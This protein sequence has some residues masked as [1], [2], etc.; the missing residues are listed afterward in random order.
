V[1]LAE[2]ASTP[3]A[4]GSDL[5]PFAGDPDFMLSLARGMLVLRCFAE[6]QDKLTIARIAAETGLTR[7]TV[8]RCLYTF[9]KLGYFEVQGSQFV[10]RVNLLMLAAAY[11]GAGGLEAALQPLLDDLR[12]RV[13]ATIGLGVRDGDHVYYA[14]VSKSTN[15][16]SFVATVGRR[17]PAYCTALGRVFLADLPEA[18]LEAYLDATEIVAHTPFATGDREALKQKIDQA[19][20]DG[21]AVAAQELEL[22]V[23]AI[24]VPIQPKGGRVVAAILAAGEM[25]QMSD[26]TLTGLFLPEMRRTAQEIALLWNNL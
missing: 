9:V 17:V 2:G 20:A 4:L 23:R 5:D 11:K 25:S 12:A 3:A 24:A 22:G 26:E 1:T 21:Y 13:G 19:R 8:R 6:S 14:A 7:S 15:T 18:E 10:P 16:L